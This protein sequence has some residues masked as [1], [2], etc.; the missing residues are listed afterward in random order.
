M[1]QLLLIYNPNSGSKSFRFSLDICIEIFQNAKYIVTIFRTQ[2]YGD[3]DEYLSTV[4]KERFD[5][6]VISG[7]DGSINIVLN[8]MMKYDL[9]KPLGII[10]SGTA[11]DFASFLKIPKI[12]QK[13]AEVIANNNITK[14]DI[15]LANNT[16]FINVFS[17]GLLTNISQQ[18]D[19][20]FKNSIGKL[21]YYLKGIE[22]IPNFVPIAVR[23]T[24]STQVIE[25]DIYL[26]FILN[27]AGTGGFDKLSKNASITD[28]YFD[29]IAIK[30]RPMVEIAV[31]FVKILSGDYFDDSGILYFTDKYIKIECLSDNPM[32]N[33]TDID[34]EVGPDLP[35][36]VQNIHNAI[37]IFIP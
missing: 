10:P 32:H 6:F 3:I 26:F 1:K 9:R 18:V 35:A 2:T 15:G 21:A 30:A 11:N 31:L 4:E 28:G 23:I 36:T 7:G 12:P 24:N 27:S 14:C 19:P 13:A 5:T 34:G 20:N 25:E 29:F 8:A 16:Y 33:E 17:A 37:E 22:Q